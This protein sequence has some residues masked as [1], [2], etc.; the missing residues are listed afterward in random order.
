[1]IKQISGYLKKDLSEERTGH[2]WWHTYR[3]WNLALQIAKEEKD[4]DLFIVQLGALL[5][6]VADWKFHSGDEKEGSK[7]VRELLEKMGAD[8]KTIQHVCDIVVNVSFKGAGVKAKIMKTKEGMI[9]QDADRL[10]ALGAIAVARTFTYGGFM[11]RT[12]HNPNIK[13][14]FHKT[15]KSYKDESTTSIKKTTSINHFHEK[16]LL[17]KELM[18]TKTAKK[19]ADGRHEFMEKYLKEFYEEWDGKK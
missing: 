10:D 6:D 19:I 14:K 5:H 2:D 1:M 3:V 9:V 4:A 15:F 11:G 17:L 18:N 7:V 16:L 12:I 8:E 13:P